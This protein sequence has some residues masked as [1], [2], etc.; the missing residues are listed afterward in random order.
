MADNTDFIEENVG[1]AFWRLDT[2]APNGDPLIL[3][4]ECEE[5]DQEMNR[6]RGT[7]FKEFLK[8]ERNTH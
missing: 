1:D 5:L 6:E 8:T 7:S 2:E 3:M 4:I